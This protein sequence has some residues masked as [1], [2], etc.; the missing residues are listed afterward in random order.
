MLLRRKLGYAAALILLI[1]ARDLF[2]TCP[3]DASFHICREI[4]EVLLLDRESAITGG[5]LVHLISD[6]FVTF[7]ARVADNP[8]DSSVSTLDKAHVHS[9]LFNRIVRMALHCQWG[10]TDGPLLRVS[11]HFDLVWLIGELKPLLLDCHRLPGDGQPVSE[12]VDVRDRR[13]FEIKNTQT[14]WLSPSPPP[15]FF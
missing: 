3:S 5:R 6:L 14:Q 7:L 10:G 2:V 12:S 15:L 9:V 13:G 4:L 1:D 11:G 8:R